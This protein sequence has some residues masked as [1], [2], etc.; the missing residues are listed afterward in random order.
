M[1]AAMFGD[2]T[3]A[4]GQPQH[5]WLASATAQAATAR[6]SGR[7]AGRRPRCGGR[8][9]NARWRGGWRISLSGSARS[10]LTA[11][12]PSSRRVLVRL[13]GASLA[14][15]GWGSGLHIWGGVH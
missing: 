10:S 9:G 7:K 3:G 6:A 2:Q 11:R 5:P 1:D 15:R 12:R 8:L 14:V 4:L 13:A